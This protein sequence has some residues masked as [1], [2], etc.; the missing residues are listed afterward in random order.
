[1]SRNTD[2]QRQKLR[3]VFWLL[4]LGVLLTVALLAAWG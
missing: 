1:M 4:V 3:L 2:S